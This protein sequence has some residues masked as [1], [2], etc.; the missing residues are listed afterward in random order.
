MRFLL[1]F[2]DGRG[3]KLDGGV[4]FDHDDTTVGADVDAIV[5]DAGLLRLMCR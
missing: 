5:G 2:S 3:G 4:E 1:R